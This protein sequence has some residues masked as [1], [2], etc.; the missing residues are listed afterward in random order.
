VAAEVWRRQPSWLERRCCEV[1]GS[2]GLARALLT[3]PSLVGGVADLDCACAR[4]GA[5]A[6]VSS[7]LP[8]VGAVGSGGG[9]GGVAYA[10]GPGMDPA[11][12]LSRSMA[13]SD[14][15]V[16]LLRA[17]AVFAVN[18]GL[19]LA[20]SGASGLAASVTFG[21]LVP[22]T[23]V[24]ALALAAATV[25]RSANVGVAAGMGWLGSHRLRGPSK[26]G[27]VEC[28]DH[29]LGL[30]CSLPDLR[31]PAV[32]RCGDSCYPCSKGSVMNIDI[33]HLTRKFGRTQAVAGVDLQ[34][35]PGCFGL[36]GPNGAGKT[37]LLRMM[38]TVLQPSSEACSCWA[39]TLASYSQRREI[40]RR[41]GYLPQNLG[42]YPGL[43]RGVRRVLRAL[44]GNAPRSDTGCSGWPP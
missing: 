33:D 31:G 23:A 15:M 12:E 3:T 6:T 41:L 17:V 4:G 39:A 44:E 42:Y 2:P 25:A 28:G 29:R 24:S 10:Y 38:A 5:A 21:W 14:R 43:R 27:P 18:A 37:S 7:G 36:L 30:G 1:V 35:A 40:R 19:G 20:A 11:W 22:M 13:V 32:A 8:L 16:L 34:V 9:G 26:F